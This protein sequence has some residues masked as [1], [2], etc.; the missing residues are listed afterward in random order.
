M[1]EK[2]DEKGLL[3][4]VGYKIIMKRCYCKGLGC[5]I[6]MKRCYCKGVGYRIIP[7]NWDWVSLTMRIDKRK[8]FGKEMVYIF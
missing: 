7:H 8:E 2:R 1:I 5:R 3:I 4:G 6:I